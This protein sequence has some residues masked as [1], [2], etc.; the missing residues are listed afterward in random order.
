MQKPISS[1]KWKY[2]TFFEC[3][4]STFASDRSGLS[5]L[6][7]QSFWSQYALLVADLIEPRVKH[8]SANFSILFPDFVTL[9]IFLKSRKISAHMLPSGFFADSTQEDSVLAECQKTSLKV[10]S[11]HGFFRQ[12][13]L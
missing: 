4:F 11:L 7:A 13:N 2:I 5:C 1:E 10:V 12:N 9:T 3:S 6:L 8:F